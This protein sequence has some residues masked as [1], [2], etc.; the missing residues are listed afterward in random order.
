V[1]TPF[2][3]FYMLCGDGESQLAFESGDGGCVELFP[4]KLFPVVNSDPQVDFREFFPYPGAVS[5]G[6]TSADNKLPAPT[7]GFKECLLEDRLNRL[8]LGF[9][10]ECAGI[11]D[12]DIGLGKIND[13]I[14]ARAFE[15]VQDTLAVDLVFAATEVVQGD[16]GHE[17][18]LSGLL[19]EVGDPIYTVSTIFLSIG[20]YLLRIKRSRY[21]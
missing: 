4:E 21:L 18:K 11:D 12:N 10:N 9:A 20:K 14:V 6:E 16:I 5:F 19:E 1:G 8:F 15:K 13:A 17:M 3:D 7:L 2:G